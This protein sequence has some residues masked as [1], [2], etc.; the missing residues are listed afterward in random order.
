MNKA[1]IIK[2]LAEGIGYLIS[3]VR[4]AYDLDDE[5]IDAAIYLAKYKYREDSC[6]A[7]EEVDEAVNKDI[8]KIIREGIDEALS[9]IKTIILEK[10]NVTVHSENSEEGDII[11]LNRGAKPIH[12]KEEVES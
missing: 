5:E 6:K 2:K 11:K 8:I 10:F 12:K 1:S 4:D 7:S 3:S 9:D